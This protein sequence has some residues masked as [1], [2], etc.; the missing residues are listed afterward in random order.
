M[1]NDE[2]I[3]AFLRF[4]GDHKNLVRMTQAYEKLF[5][6]KSISEANILK[7]VM[8]LY[9]LV[10]GAGVFGVVIT[11]EGRKI[12]EEGGWL[13][14][15]QAQIKTGLQKKEDKQLQREAHKSTIE[16]NKIS[17]IYKI[18]SFWWG[19]V[20]GLISGAAGIFSIIKFFFDSSK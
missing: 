19:L 20:I 9:G 13:K 2:K 12:L 18:R 8:E 4:L 14:H 16:T 15:Q 1:S 6:T 11:H 3:D 10:K 17:R 7:S 5:G